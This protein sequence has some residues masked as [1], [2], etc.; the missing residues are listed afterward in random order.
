[1]NNLPPLI[2]M[3]AKKRKVDAVI[4]AIDEAKAELED[5]EKALEQREEA[6]KKAVEGVDQ[7]KRL[8]SAQRPTAQSAAHARNIMHRMRKLSSDI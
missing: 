4:E 8:M 7:E 1:M 3:S 6:L 2:Y 5:R